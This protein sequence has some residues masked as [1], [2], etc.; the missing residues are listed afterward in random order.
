MSITNDWIKEVINGIKKFIQ[1]E[2]KYDQPIPTKIGDIPLSW[3]I[4]IIGIG[5]L[6]NIL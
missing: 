5:I 3:I 2:C 6:I 1:F 4:I